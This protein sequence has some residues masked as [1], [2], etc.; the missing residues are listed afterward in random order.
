MT[1]TEYRTFALQPATLNATL[2]RFW[3]IPTL[4]LLNQY[5]EQRVRLDFEQQKIDYKYET[6]QKTV[7]SGTS[8][9][10]SR[11]TAI[12]NERKV[13]QKINYL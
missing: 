11:S 13:N 2:L 7:N 4:D 3:M 6:K 8:Y 5:D 9:F 1:G 10:K 12:Q